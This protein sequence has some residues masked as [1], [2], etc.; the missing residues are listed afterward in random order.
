MKALTDLIKAIRCYSEISLN[1][2]TIRFYP[3]KKDGGEK[4]SFY[5]GLKSQEKEVSYRKKNLTQEKV[6]GNKSISHKKRENNENKLL[7]EESEDFYSLD[8]KNKRYNSQ[9]IFKEES[10]FITNNKDTLNIKSDLFKLQANSRKEHSFMI[11]NIDKINNQIHRSK[12]NIREK[13]SYITNNQK[14]TKNAD[15]DLNEIT[16]KNLISKTVSRNNV[17]EIPVTINF[18]PVVNIPKEKGIKEEDILKILEK[19]ADMLTDTLNKALKK[20]Y[21]LDY[22]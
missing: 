17:K 6:I 3:S 21:R 11:K 7:N 13:Y 5:T 20:R 9:E 18:S 16:I 19:N 14:Q 10:S 4:D 12:T 2:S 8:I 15:T 1:I 22:R